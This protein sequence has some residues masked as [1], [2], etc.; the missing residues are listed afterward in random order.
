MSLKYI[1]ESIPKSSLRAIQDA[2]ES[3]M[4]CLDACAPQYML[5]DLIAHE[6]DA[7]N[8]ARASLASNTQACA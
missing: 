1:N 7:L 6:I 5:L 8:G 4:A 3:S 2:L